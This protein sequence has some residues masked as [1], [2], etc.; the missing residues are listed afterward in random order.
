MYNQINKNMSENKWEINSVWTS[1]NQVMVTI[2]IWHDLPFSTKKVVVVGTKTL[3][4]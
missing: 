2:M 1:N 3:K 4:K